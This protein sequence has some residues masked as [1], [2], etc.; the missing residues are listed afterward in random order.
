MMTEARKNANAKWDRANYCTVSCRMSKEAAG[1]LR[2]KLTR[3]GLT[4]HTF[5]RHV[6]ELYAASDDE[7]FLQMLEPQLTRAES[8]AELD[9]IV[10]G[11]SLRG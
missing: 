4:A 7:Q 10:R 5:L 11:K 8:D 1:E 9:D 6:C 3:R 2:S